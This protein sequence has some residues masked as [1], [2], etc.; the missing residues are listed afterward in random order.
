LDNFKTVTVDVEWLSSCI[1]QYKIVSFRPY[2]VTGDESAIGE[3]GY[4]PVLI[5]SVPFTLTETNI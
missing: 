1:G 4:P 5:E 3:L 2:L